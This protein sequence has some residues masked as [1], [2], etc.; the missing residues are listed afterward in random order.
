M[1]NYHLPWLL[2]LTWICLLPV[3]SQGQNWHQFR[4]PGSRG[5]SANDAL[6]LKWDYGKRTNI[7]WEVETQGRGWSSPI[8]TNG[9][10]YY[11]TVVNEG[12]TEAAKKGLYFG[13]N[14]AAPPKGVHH[15]LIICRDLTTGKLEWKKEVHHGIPSGSIHVKN[16]FASETAVTDGENLYVSFGHLGIFCVDLKGE[17]IWQRRG[18]ASKTRYDWGTAASPVLY[19][20]KLFIVDDN[21]EQSTLLA[22]DK[23]TGKELWRAKR[24]EGSNWAT[25]F[26]WENSQRTELV[27]PG[28]GMN[29]VYSLEG[30]LL[31]E[32]GG[33]SSITIAT[34]YAKD[35]LLYVSSGYVLDPKKPLFAI[36]PGA[37]GDITLG[38]QET[39]NDFIQW[40]QKEAAP[41]NPST[42]LYE[43]RIYVLY[44]RGFF[45][46]FDA[47][48]GREIY[49][50]QR[51]N[52]G[53]AFTSSPW[54]YRGH[55]FCINEYGE[56]FVIK[57][58]DTFEMTGKYALHVE[59]MAMATPSMVGDRLII[60]TAERLYSIREK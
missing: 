16:S 44:D 10:I 48:T 60:R 36:K 1:K 51:L 46:C 18:K 25:P 45:A 41:Y 33:N 55:I 39:S 59:D 56:T 26:V 58:G 32:F 29:R 22:L 27:T 49:G 31:Y 53:R 34:P 38:D 2:C 20:D 21:E 13:G 8:V 14:R 4:G 11:S 30:E 35:D 57:A 9:K 17:L 42:L 24:P 43:G 37:S 47:K 50:K 28:T 3:E 12:A 19:K 23:A 5:V 6:P 15:W 52:G 40:C 54:A 7:E